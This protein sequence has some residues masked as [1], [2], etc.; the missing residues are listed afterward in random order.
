MAD[1]YFFASINHVLVCMFKLLFC[2]DFLT[3]CFISIIQS[4]LERIWKPDH[5]NYEEDED[6][7]AM[8]VLVANANHLVKYVTK[9]VL[10]WGEPWWSV[11][12]V[13]DFTNNL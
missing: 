6:Q 5:P 10:E 2:F 4:L 13:S 12:Y 9:E 8:S 3:L 7:L 11:D 1:A